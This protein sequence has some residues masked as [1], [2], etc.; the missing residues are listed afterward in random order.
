[1]SEQQNT[2]NFGTATSL[3]VSGNDPAGSGKDKWALIKWDLSSVCGVVQSGSL[4][5]NITDHA[6]GQTYELYDALAG[7]NNTAVTW[8]NKP[9][10]GAGI[11]GSFGPSRLGAATV[12]LNAAGL[13]RLQYWLNNPTK[14]YG[15][16]L[17]DGANTDT[18]AFDSRDR[19]IANLRPKLT[20]TYKPA[21]VTSGPTIQSIT[22]TSAKV[23][24]ESDVFCKETLRYR[25]QGTVTWTSK[26]VMAV[27]TN[28]KWQVAANLTGLLTNTTYEY[29]LRASTDSAWTTTRIFR[30]LS[31]VG[32]D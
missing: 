4:S 18:L 24:W 6:G 3:I 19:S 28:G 10:R 30:T 15:F 32:P 27:L 25:K 5:F 17:M 26:N 14:N 31:A 20:V 22:A 1:M 7:W 29:Q 2:T 16:Y 13:E 23:V 8:N 12:S 11:L 21:V 9:A